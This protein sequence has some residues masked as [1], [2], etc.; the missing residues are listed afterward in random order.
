MSPKSE[1]RII[2]IVDD[3]PSIRKILTKK[4]RSRFDEILTASTAKEAARLLFENRI[5]HLLCDCNLGPD[6]PASYKLIPAWRKAHPSISRA[7]IFSGSCLSDKRIPDE[8]DSVVAK[9]E[10]FEKLLSALLSSPTDEPGVREVAVS[11]TE[12]IGE[13]AGFEF[14]ERNGGRKHKKSALKII[15][16]EKIEIRIESDIV[17]AR[18]TGRDMAR[19]L[20]FSDVDSFKISIAIS[21]L[22]QNV[23]LHAGAGTISLSAVSTE[24]NEVGLT[25]VVEDSGPGIDDIERAMR[26]GYSTSNSLGNGL[27]GAKRLLDAFE[28]RS[29]VGK[30]TVVTAT[31]WIP[32]VE[33][34]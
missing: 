16:L 34:R 28:I 26:D 24:N 5:T 18:K 3:D 25:M 1:K 6:S 31:K 17:I 9:G 20:G 4:L 11:E 10:E 13:S 15:S 29:E 14:D 21:E 12:S 22:V 23:L 33:E 32:A 2:L 30:G 27:P 7:V 19:S 8:V